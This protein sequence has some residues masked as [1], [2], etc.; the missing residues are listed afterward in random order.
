MLQ[1]NDDPTSPPIR[2]RTVGLALL[3]GTLACVVHM[4]GKQ[5]SITEVAVIVL[6]IVT[7]FIIWE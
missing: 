1:K 6:A 3:S 5:D 4:L 2:S 7:V